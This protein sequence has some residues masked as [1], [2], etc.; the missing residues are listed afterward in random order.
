[1]ERTRATL[2]LV[3]EYT[4]E[5]FTFGGVILAVFVYLDFRSTVQQMNETNAN[6]VKVLN[7]IELRIHNLEDYHARET[8]KQ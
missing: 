7:A 3:R 1:M 8:R 5:V 2:A 4:R 6:T